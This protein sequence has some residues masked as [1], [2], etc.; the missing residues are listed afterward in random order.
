MMDAVK[1]NGRRLE[2]V[3]DEL[4]NDKDIAMAA[5]K[6]DGYAFLKHATDE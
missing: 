3:S 2:Y 6:R 4:K 1:R 5:V